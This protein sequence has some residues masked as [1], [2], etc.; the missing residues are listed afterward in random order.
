M[1][2]YKEQYKKELNATSTEELIEKYKQIKDELLYMEDCVKSDNINALQKSEFLT[3][4]IPTAKQDIMY[5]EEILNS[6]K[7]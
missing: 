2:N 6:R 4:D 5:I 3:N 7:K 1:N